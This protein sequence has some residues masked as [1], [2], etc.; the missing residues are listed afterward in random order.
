MVGR[1]R[2]VAVEL[3]DEAGV[4]PVEVDLVALDGEVPSR[5]AQALGVEEREEAVLG[6]ASGD[7]SAVVRVARSSRS[8]G[9]TSNARAMPRSCRSNRDDGTAGSRR[10][11]A[12]AVRP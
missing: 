5:A 10:N 11:R 4:G 12:K 2:G 7:V 1:V 9:S 3:D 6:F 8:A